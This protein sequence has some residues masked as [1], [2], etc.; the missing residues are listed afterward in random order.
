MH[1]YCSL[2]RRAAY[3]SRLNLVLRRGNLAPLCKNAR[4]RAVS[5]Y[6]DSCWAGNDGNPIAGW[7]SRRSTLFHLYSVNN[8]TNYEGCERIMPQSTP[9]LSRPT[10]RWASPVLALSIVVDQNSEFSTVTSRGFASTPH[11]G[12]IKTV[13]SSFTNVAWGKIALMPTSILHRH[14]YCIVIY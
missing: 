3:P 5:S 9:A 10:Y 8:T 12:P 13:P 4:D 7:S 1:A 6:E 14:K 2:E 11:H